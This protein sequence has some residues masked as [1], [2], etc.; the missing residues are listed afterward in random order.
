MVAFGCAAL[1][2][3]I[4]V[5][6]DHCDEANTCTLTKKDIVGFAS[7]KVAPSDCTPCMDGIH[8]K[9]RAHHHLSQSLCFRP[10]RHLH[11]CFVCEMLSATVSS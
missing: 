4:Q 1:I 8:W 5:A 2:K 11:T 3:Q 9:C 6:E 7:D 10:L